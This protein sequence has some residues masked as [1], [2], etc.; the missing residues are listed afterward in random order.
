MKRFKGCDAYLRIRDRADFF[1]PSKKVSPRR[2][3]GHK[4]SQLVTNSTEKII[5][6]LEIGQKVMSPPQFRMKKVMALFPDEFW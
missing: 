2:K 3:S 5:P 4:K 1:Q 6:L